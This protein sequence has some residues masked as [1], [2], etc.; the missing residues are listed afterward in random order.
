MEPPCIRCP[1]LDSPSLVLYNL[2]LNDL[3]NRNAIVKPITRW[4]TEQQPSIGKSAPVQT[5]VCL[6]ISELRY[7]DIYP[8]IKTRKLTSETEHTSCEVS[9]V[10]R[11]LLNPVGQGHTN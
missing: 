10:Y 9:A 7:H 11:V 8:Y 3:Q 5:P 2:I 6:T 4:Q 1:L